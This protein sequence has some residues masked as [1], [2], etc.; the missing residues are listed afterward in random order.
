MKQI[1]T[2]YESS[3]KDNKIENIPEEYTPEDLKFLKGI[4]DYD[5]FKDFIYDIVKHIIEHYNDE[6]TM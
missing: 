6:L 4:V 3:L 1:Q 5:K 2:Y